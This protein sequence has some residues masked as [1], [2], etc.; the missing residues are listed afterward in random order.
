MKLPVIAI[1]SNELDYYPF[2]MVMPGRS[3]QAGSEDGYKFG[4][5]SQENDPELINGA[6]NFKY[7][8]EDARIGRFLSI[9]PLSIKY[10][11]NSPYTFSEN[12]LING[13]EFEGLEFLFGLFDLVKFSPALENNAVIPKTAPIETLEKIGDVVVRQGK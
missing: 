4:F 9:D 13:R 3:Y 6:I 10:P 11:F 12:K 8:I 7:R 5:Q 2:G 1:E